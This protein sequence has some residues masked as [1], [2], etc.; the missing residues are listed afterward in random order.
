M[1]PSRRRQEEEALKAAALFERQLASMAMEKKAQEEAWK[2]K[3]RALARELGGDGGKARVRC[4]R[5]HGPRPA[6][7]QASRDACVN[8]PARVN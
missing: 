1:S 7:S 5:L 3:E 2:M 6:G 8:G 4:C